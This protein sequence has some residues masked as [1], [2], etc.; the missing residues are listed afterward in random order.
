MHSVFSFRRLTLL[1]M[2]AGSTWLMACNNNADNKDKKE[3]TVADAS[4]ATIDHTQHTPSG[5]ESPMD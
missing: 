2:A 4:S 5:P 1:V 3:D